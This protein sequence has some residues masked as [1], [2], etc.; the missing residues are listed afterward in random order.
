M[1]FDLSNERDS[2]IRRSPRG[3]MLALNLAERYGWQPAGTRLANDD[4]EVVDGWDGLYD[5]NDGQQVVE[6]DALAL[7]KALR[8][9]TASPRFQE[10][11]IALYQD[12]FGIAPRT[13][14][15][16]LRR[17]VSQS[18]LEDQRQA[19]TELATFCE[20]GSFTIE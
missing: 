15:L 4:G 6:S 11:L 3:W 17:S 7:G 5:T 14:F 13:G 12:L 9:A 1:G 16:K 19:M 10:D 2:Y 20:E 8:Q 18:E